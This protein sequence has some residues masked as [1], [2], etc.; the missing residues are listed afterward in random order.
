MYSVW[1]WVWVWQ[2]GG[3]EE[4]VIH[5]QCITLNQKSWSH[6][7]QSSNP[8]RIKNEPKNRTKLKAIQQE[9]KL[10]IATKLEKVQNMHHVCTVLC[11]PLRVQLARCWG[12][13]PVLFTEPQFETT[14][15]TTNSVTLSADKTLTQKC[16]CQ[17]T[18]RWYYTKTLTVLLFAD[19]MRLRVSGL[20]LL[21]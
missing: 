18:K 14:E 10:S 2:K 8:L 1:V 6:S 12:L 3:S 15:T 5:W 9:N 7:N 19:R 16:N 20:N 17:N 21:S 4:V 11:T 13:C